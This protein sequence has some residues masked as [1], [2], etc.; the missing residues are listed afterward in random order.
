MNRSADTKQ[1]QINKQDLDPVEKTLHCNKVERSNSTVVSQSKSQT[2]KRK[3]EKAN[4]FFPFPRWKHGKNLDSTDSTG[5]FEFQNCCQPTNQNLKT[6][7]H[8]KKESGCC[9]VTVVEAS[10]VGKACSHHSSWETNKCKLLTKSNL[11]E[12]WPLW[13][14]AISATG[15]MEELSSPTCTPPPLFPAKDISATPPKTTLHCLMKR[16]SDLW[17]AL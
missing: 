8:W 17:K 10:V 11:L 15:F 9:G 5:M 12:Q 3:P 1:A 7:H 2:C 6:K 13:E 16:V 4:T 14:S